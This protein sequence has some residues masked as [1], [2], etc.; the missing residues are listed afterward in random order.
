MTKSGL[1]DSQI[2]AELTPRYATDAEVEFAAWLRH[3]LEERY[4]EHSDSP[5]EMPV[6]AD[7]MH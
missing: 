1:P 5:P 2:N 6:P 7:E 4:L 3:R